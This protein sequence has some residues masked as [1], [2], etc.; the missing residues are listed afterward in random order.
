MAMAN[1]YSKSD[2][3]LL[4]SGIERDNAAQMHVVALLIDRSAYNSILRW[5]PFN[6]RIIAARYKCIVRNVSIIE[7]YAPTEMPSQDEKG[8][9]YNTLVGIVNR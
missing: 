5:D 7:S 2:K 1:T 3:S 9:F 8:R 4:F 6:E